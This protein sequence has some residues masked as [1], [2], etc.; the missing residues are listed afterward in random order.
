VWTRHDLGDPKARDPAAHR[1]VV[2]AIPVSQQPARGGV[3][4]ERLR[5]VAEPSTP[6]SDARCN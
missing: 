5:S 2:D 6:T 1:L 4:R 3:P